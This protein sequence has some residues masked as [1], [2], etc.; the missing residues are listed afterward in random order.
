M[1]TIS[2]RTI[3]NGEQVNNVIIAGNIAFQTK[4]VQGVFNDLHL[5]NRFA[6]PRKLKTIG[7]I[8]S[9]QREI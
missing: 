9:L 4:D 5:E 2:T 7:K 3:V 1:D 8:K 6:T